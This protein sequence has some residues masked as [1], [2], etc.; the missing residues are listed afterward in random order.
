MR[1]LVID[2]R[3]NGGGYLEAAVEVVDQFI[4]GGKRIVYTQGRIEDSFREYFSTYSALAP[5]IPVL[6]MIDRA[7]ASAS[8][9]VAGAL[10]DWD[11]A[12]IMGETSFGKGLVQRQYMLRDGSALLMTT[13]RYYTPSG[14]MI[15]RPYG[16]KSHEEYYTEIF[17]DS[18]RDRL[19]H[20]ISRPR[21]NTLIL[22]R[23]VLG[24]GGITPDILFSTD[25]DT[26]SDIIRRLVY[27]PDRLIFSFVN[28]YM[29][30]L[31]HHL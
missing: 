16:D 17:D 28:L 20:D 31:V 1:R 11:R 18:Q 3:Q 23:Q 5:H 10:Q 8:E 14:R 6:V 21:M 26:I 27:H 22:Q 9:I 24:G 25:A 7:S 30:L 2:L 4:P 13:A 19:S 29:S 12:L 15:Q